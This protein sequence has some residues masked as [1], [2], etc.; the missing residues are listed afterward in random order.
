L[1]LRTADAD[2]GAAS[3]LQSVKTS[4]PLTFFE[5]RKVV[6]YVCICVVDKLRPSWVYFASHSK[7]RFLRG[8]PP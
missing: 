8:I 5:L 3:H 4:Y 7:E 6:V 1:P 2:G